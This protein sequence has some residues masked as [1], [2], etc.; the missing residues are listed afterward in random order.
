ML[1]R[2][3]EITKK[4]IS[5]KENKITKHKPKSLKIVVFQK[6]GRREWL[7][8]SGGEMAFCYWQGTV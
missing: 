8:E 3:M 2:D 4:N 7:G 1:S 5:K 6:R